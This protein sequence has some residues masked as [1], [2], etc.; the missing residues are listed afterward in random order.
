MRSQGELWMWCMLVCSH[1]MLLI[2]NRFNFVRVSCFY[3]PSNSHHQVSRGRCAFSPVRSQAPAPVLPVHL[4]ARART[5]Y[6]PL[7]MT[8]STDSGWQALKHRHTRAH[9]YSYWQSA[10]RTDRLTSQR[11]ERINHLLS[12]Y[13][14]PHPFGWT[15]SYWCCLSSP[16]ITN[17]LWISKSTHCFFPWVIYSCTNADEAEPP[18]TLKWTRGRACVNDRCRCFIFNEHQRKNKSVNLSNGSIKHGNTALSPQKTA[19][20]QICSLNRNSLRYKHAGLFSPL[21][22]LPCLI[23]CYDS[24]TQQTRS[25]ISIDLDSGAS[26]ISPWTL[27][28]MGT[29]HPEI[30]NASVDSCFSCCSGEGWRI[31]GDIAVETSAFS[32]V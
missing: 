31:C 27:P 7:E 11:E 32:S 13:N 24:H 12:S 26:M 20:D 6:A 4:A 29:V 25:N 23:S 9:K 22:S 1:V 16:Y 5:V 2:G 17:N 14:K 15:G 30:I 8:D 10:S 3:F 28:D 18:Y 21:L 19:A